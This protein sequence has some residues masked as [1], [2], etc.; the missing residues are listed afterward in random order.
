MKYKI[1]ISQIVE[2]EVQETEYKRTGEEDEDKNDIYEYVKT[3]KLIIDRSEKT[4][5]SQEK[6]DLDVAELAIYINRAR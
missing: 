3:G 4:I 1:E 5:Y 2:E 6:E